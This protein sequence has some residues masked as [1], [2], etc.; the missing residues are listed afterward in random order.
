MASGRRIRIL[1]DI[2]DLRLAGLLKYD[3]KPVVLECRWPVVNGVDGKLKDL[4]E[5][6]S[7]PGV[8]A[9]E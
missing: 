7:I 6:H 5:L 4:A 9:H 2:Q 8:L 1:V 3:T